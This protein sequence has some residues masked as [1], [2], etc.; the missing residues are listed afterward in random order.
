MSNEAATIWDRVWR[1][2]SYS[3]HE[4]RCQKAKKK[5]DLFGDK[6]E[7]DAQSVCVDLGC[8]GGYVSHEIAARFACK[9]IGIDFSDA[10][11]QRAG[12]TF[13]ASNANCVFKH[14]PVTKIP[15]PDNCADAVLCIGIL[16]H[17]P[18]LEQALSE[19]KRILRPNGQV[20]IFTS[21][22]Y[23]IMYFDRLLKQCFR[24][25]RYG[26]QKNWSPKGLKKRLVSAGISP[27]RVETVQGFGDFPMKN[28]IDALIH[29]LIGAWGRYFMLI[30]RG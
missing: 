15:L 5:V 8:G 28:R 4:L 30:G 10:A 17:V 22:R 27:V 19:I 29:G 6:L 14:G 23:S 20:V 21:N 24:V 11:I 16:E 18:E 2:D 12:K 3:E 26:Y 1:K 7:L 25:W 13:G 9:T